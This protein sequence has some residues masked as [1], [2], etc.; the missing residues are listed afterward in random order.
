MK[1][2]QTT[3]FSTIATLISGIFLPLQSQATVPLQQQLV[4]QASIEDIIRDLDG[5]AYILGADK[6]ELGVVS[7]NQYAT[8]S[9]CNQYGK[10]GSRYSSTSVWN[11]YGK[12]GSPYSTIGAYNPRGHKPPLIVFEGGAFILSKNLN[13]D[14]RIDPD[15]LFAV[16]CR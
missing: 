1:S 13:L 16:L 11:E 5:N 15:Y 12:Y 14:N 9:I 4:A 7:S 2:L 6:Q 8:E 3:V 10:Y